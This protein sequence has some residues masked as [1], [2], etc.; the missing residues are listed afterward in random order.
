MTRTPTPTQRW[1]ADHPGDKPCPMDGLAA[2]MWRS[3]AR[4]FCAHFGYR[5]AH[6]TYVHPKTIDSAGGIVFGSFPQEEKARS[7]VKQAQKSGQ[8]QVTGLST[9]ND[10]RSFVE[11]LLRRVRRRWLRGIR[12]I[13]MLFQHDPAEPVGVWLELREDHRGLY[14][15]GRL[16][17]E[18]ARARAGLA[19]LYRAMGRPSDS[20]QAI[21]DLVRFSPTPEAHSVAAEL[22]TMFGEPGRAAEIRRRSPR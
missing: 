2:H 8:V 11:R 16:I 14:A 9:P 4:E 19:M 5:T 21:A 7:A 18:V 17:P 22:W 1:M 12:R 13:P 10:M 15:R 6:A 3:S 20:E